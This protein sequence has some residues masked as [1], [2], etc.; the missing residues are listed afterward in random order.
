MRHLFCVFAFLLCTSK[1]GIA[2]PQSSKLHVVASFSVLGDFVK[3]IAGDCVIL[4]TIVGANEDAHVFTPTPKDVVLLKNAD[5]I[6]MNGLG[7]EGWIPRLVETAGFEGDLVVVSQGV[8]SYQMPGENT[9]DPHGW[10]DIRNAIVYV[11]NIIKALAKADPCHAAYY[12]QR[13]GQYLARLSALDHK[14]RLEFQTVPLRKRQVITAHDA[15]Q[16][17]GRAYGVQ[18]FAPVG[19]STEEEASA[20]DVARLIRQIR[21]TNIRSVFVENISNEK[22][23]RQI[24]E[25][26]GVEVGGVLYS[27]A[28]SEE[29]GPASTYIK[30][31]Q[32]NAQQILSSFKEL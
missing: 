27:D 21:E 25:E 15:F 12:R 6:L 13:G 2:Q 18:F 8:K 22:L 10:H 11:K 9:Q 3:E 4:S 24:A 1:V 30:M 31:M 29:S 19:V 20:A 16:Y 32:H 7:F 23:I 28:L 5:L 17:F 26:T 14:I